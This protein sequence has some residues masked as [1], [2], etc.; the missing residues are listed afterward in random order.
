MGG[1]FNVLAEIKHIQYVK[2]LFGS[3]AVMIVYMYVEV[4]CD[5]DFTIGTVVQSQELREFIKEFRHLIQ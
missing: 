4:T 2:K 3:R 1:P 5:N